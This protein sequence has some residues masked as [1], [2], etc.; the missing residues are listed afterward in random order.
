V[1][2]PPRRDCGSWASAGVEDGIGN[3]VGPSC[4][5]C[6]SVT[7]SE[8]KTKLSWV[9]ACSSACPCLPRVLLVPARLRSPE[10]RSFARAIE[11]GRWRK[12]AIGVDGPGGPPGTEVER[13]A[14]PGTR[15]DPYVS[16]SAVLHVDH[17]Q[18]DGAR[19]HA[20]SL[21]RL[22]SPGP[23]R[24]NSSTSTSTCRGQHGREEK[25]IVTFPQRPGIAVAVADVQG[26]RFAPHTGG[27]RC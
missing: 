10:P 27:K 2:R 24:A 1:S 7:D 20:Y 3:L 19:S 5:G 26:P 22:R 4:P 11:A 6:P 13:T 12:P 17:A 23:L 15:P 14:D 8:V 9:P 21:K 18:P 25:V 16:M